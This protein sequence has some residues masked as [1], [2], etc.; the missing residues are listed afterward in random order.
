[1][2]L[3]LLGTSKSLVGSTN[4]ADDVARFREKLD[5][6]LKSGVVSLV[7]LL[8]IDRSGP[9]YGYRI[10]KNI[11]EWSGGHLAFKEGTAYPLLQN[12]E[13]SGMLTSFWGDGAGG[14]PRKYYQTTALGREALK[15]ALADW[16]SLTGSVD[17]IRRNI[18]KGAKQP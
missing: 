17:E 16:E 15:T 18:P 1:M 10:L 12:L 14:P 2:Y 8:V 6:E 13:R 4:A 5:R 7:L 3:G 11:Q 9:D